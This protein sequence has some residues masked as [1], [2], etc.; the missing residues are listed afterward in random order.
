M[1]NYLVFNSE[2]GH[3][4]RKSWIVQTK[5]YHTGNYSVNTNP[6]FITGNN[7]VTKFSQSHFIR[8][9]LNK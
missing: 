6:V 2:T 8:L 9:C 1:W 7:A 3:D 5:V 4:N